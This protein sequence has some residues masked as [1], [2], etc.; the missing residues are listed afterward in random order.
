MKKEKNRTCDFSVAVNGEMVGNSGED[1]YLCMPDRGIAAVFDGCGG[2]GAR[3]YPSE[4]GH[5]GAYLAA[6]RAAAVLEACAA[7]GEG[8]LPARY[9]SALRTAIAEY[10]AELNE[11]NGNLVLRTDMQR[12]LPST[13]AVALTD[14]RSGCCDILWAGDS[15]IYLLDGDGL[16]CLNYA[17]EETFLSDARLTNY[18]NADIPFTLER[19]RITLALPC[20]VIAATDGAYS[21]F[22]TPMEFEYMLLETLAAASS[23]ADLE[24]GLDE[25]IARYAGD[26]YTLCALFLGHGSFDGAKQHTAPRYRL[27]RSAY[28][29]PLDAPGA[30]ADRLWESYKQG[31]LRGTD[32]RHD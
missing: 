1:T 3:R 26:D 16:H 2:L 12:S 24:R 29:E 8:D 13:A 11:K 19:K 25:A 17:D 15:H 23:P 18:I 31:F 32:V 9:E 5:T 22:R 30:D 6:R 4:G 7:D 28:I 14:Y 10:N 27:M 21:Y 20:A